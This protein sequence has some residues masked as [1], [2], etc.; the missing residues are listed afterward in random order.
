MRR[1]VPT[2]TLLW[3]I[4]IT[5]K[6]QNFTTECRALSPKGPLVLHHLFELSRLIKFTVVA[7]TLI[8][9]L[10]EL[11]QIFILLQFLKDLVHIL[12]P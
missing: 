9:I 3:H 5:S 10:P 6:V 8:F 2:D 7:G 1:G 4:F 12:L 11:N